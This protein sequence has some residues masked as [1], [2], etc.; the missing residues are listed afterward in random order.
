[1]AR[2]FLDRGY[3]FGQRGDG[4]NWLGADDW[5]GSRQYRRTIRGDGV[6]RG[7]ASV[8][9]GIGGGDAWTDFAA[10][11]PADY[12][13]CGDSLGCESTADWCCAGDCRVD[14]VAL[15]AAASGE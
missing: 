9:R 3:D 8:Q 11:R 14:L 6:G 12:D 10:G 4:A 1:M 15:A 5:C 13:Q 2:D 7:C